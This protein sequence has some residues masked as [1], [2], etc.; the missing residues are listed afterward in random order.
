MYNSVNVNSDFFFF[1]LIKATSYVMTTYLMGQFVERL[2]AI[3]YVHGSDKGI[4]IKQDCGYNF[5]ILI[6]NWKLLG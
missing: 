3:F 6:N 5:Q 2:Y 1:L 4:W